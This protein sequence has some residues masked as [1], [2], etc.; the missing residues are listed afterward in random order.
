MMHRPLG[1]RWGMGRAALL[2]A[3]VW[4]LPVQAQVSVEGEVIDNVTGLPVQG[5]IVQF[6]DVGVAALTDLMGYF[7]F[8][9]VPRGTQIISTYHF[10]YD[11]LTAETPIVLGDVLA[12][13]LTPRPI[14]L[15][16]VSV[17]VRPR[18]EIEA[19]TSG[20]SSDFLGPELIEAQAE[21]HTR[22]LEVM[23][24]KAPPRLQIRQQSSSGGMQFCIQSS[25]QSP[26]IQELR[27]LG[28]GCRQAMLVM[29]GIVI[30][31]PPSTSDFVGNVA[32][33]LP[34]DVANMLLNQNP[35]EIESIRVLT[36]TDAFFRYGDP[37]RLGAVEVV[38]KRPSNRVR[39]R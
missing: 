26:S 11:A 31:A 29:D 6:P 24:A 19:L 4:G 13:N 32:P 38:T 18:G 34:A 7:R 21:R 9:A 15:G 5:V 10:A 28:T 22:V 25:R 27:D 12:L 23:R 1:V 33:S 35:N 37:G 14:P 8:D 20:R 3:L 39:R 16:G 30:Y 2:A 36:P 17:D